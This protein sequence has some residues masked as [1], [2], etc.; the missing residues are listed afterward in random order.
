MGEYD[1][2]PYG[3]QCLVLCFGG[4]TLTCA[5]DTLI[6]VLDIPGIAMASNIDLDS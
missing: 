1:V 4:C 6:P 2:E 5:G 3:V